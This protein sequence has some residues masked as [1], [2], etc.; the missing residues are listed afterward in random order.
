MRPL[1]K[2]AKAP[3]DFFR[4]FCWTQ[5]ADIRHCARQ[6]RQSGEVDWIASV[7]RAALTE[8]I[9]VDGVGIWR[10][11][12]LAHEKN[13]MSSGFFHGRIPHERGRRAGRKA[14]IIRFSQSANHRG[15][16]ITLFWRL[17]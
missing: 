12:A 5:N 11:T 4:A 9:S 10:E 1:R 15:T 3:P 13:R 6:A 16:E 2:S 8:D 17:A 14:L 7:S